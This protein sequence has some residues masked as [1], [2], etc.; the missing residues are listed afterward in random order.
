MPPF[1]PI[2]DR[3]RTKVDSSG[4]F[5]AC[6]PFTGS[7]TGGYGRLGRSRARGT[8]G[9]HRI[10]LELKLGRPLRRGFGAL[11]TCDNTSCCN[12]AH[13]YEGKQKHNVADCIE[14]G[15]RVYARGD[16]HGAR[17]HPESRPRGEANKGGGKLKE[18]DVIEIRRAYAA[19]EASQ[20]AL[21]RRFGVSQYVVSAIVRGK[22][23]AH[24]GGI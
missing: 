7:L 6:W 14:R 13:L 22:L 4:G 16:S 21:G 1:K 3:L 24:V 12:P 19:G 18:R 5:D 9:A 8:V 20:D 23:W 11:H 15:R 10:A 17:L 2:A